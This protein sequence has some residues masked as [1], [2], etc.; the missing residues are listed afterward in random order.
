M[1]KFEEQQSETIEIIQNGEV[2]YR[3]ENGEVTLDNRNIESTDDL[4]I[5]S[6]DET[7]EQ[8]ET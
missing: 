3:Q 4:D 5:N 6:E 1:I 8:S 2:V 7:Q